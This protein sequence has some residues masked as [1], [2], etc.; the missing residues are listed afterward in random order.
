MEKRLSK[1]AEI[2]ISNF[3]DNIKEKSCQLGLIKNDQ[4]NQLLQYIY[5]YE[6]R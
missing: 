3:K 4:V 1:K 5:D 2:Y 6:Q